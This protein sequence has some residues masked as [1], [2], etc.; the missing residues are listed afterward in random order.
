[1][2]IKENV[3]KLSDMSLLKNID[4]TMKIKEA[5][6]KLDDFCK[7]N[8]I[9][10]MVTGTTALAMLGVPSNPQDID[11]KVFHLK[12]EQKA[13]LK[14]LQFLSGLRNENYEEST[15]YTFVIG[16]VKINAIIDKTESYDEIISKEVVL[17]I[18]DEPRA[19]HHLIGVQLVALALKD[20][21][22]LRRYKDKE[23]M[24]NLIANLASL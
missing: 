12:E 18:I 3:I 8:K 20:K 23:Y 6:F 5:L 2:N 7:V 24:L 11:I 16:G 10:Y 21:M 1:M 4:N 19:K 22:K 14:E 9:E 17:D 13:K 15:C